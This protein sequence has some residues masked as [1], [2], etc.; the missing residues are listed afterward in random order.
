MSLSTKSDELCNG[1][2]D[3]K[4][5]CTTVGSKT[6]AQLRTTWRSA[7]N[8]AFNGEKPINRQA[9]TNTAILIVGIMSRFPARNCARMQT[10]T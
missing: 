2:L 4:E 9:A 8:A 3:G 5:L 7:K 10:F 1:A 6:G